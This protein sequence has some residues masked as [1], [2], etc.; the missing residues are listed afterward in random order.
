[1]NDQ[2]NEVQLDD[3]PLRH[4]AVIHTLRPA[5]APADRELLL[6]LTELGFLPG[7]RVRITAEGPGGREPLA[8]RVGHTTF[9]LRRREASFIL[10]RPH[11]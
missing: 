1:M 5:V 4:W 10:V 6:R 2:A 3:L 9:A 11:A 8:V 7:E